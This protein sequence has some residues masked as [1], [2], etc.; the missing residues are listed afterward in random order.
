MTRTLEHCFVDSASA[1]FCLCVTHVAGGW[2]DSV[3]V[4]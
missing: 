2:P 3:Q 4:N 1:G